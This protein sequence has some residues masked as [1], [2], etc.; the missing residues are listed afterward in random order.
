MMS[1]WIYSLANKRGVACLCV[2]AFQVLGAEKAKGEMKLLYSS[3]SENKS[4]KWI[5]SQH[6]YVP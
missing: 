6:F 4:T 3:R 1:Y 5:K 2:A